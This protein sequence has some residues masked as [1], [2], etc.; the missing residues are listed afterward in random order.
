[1]KYKEKLKVYL[2]MSVLNF[3]FALDSPAEMGIT[4]KF[5]G[6][7]RK[8][9]FEAFIS[10]VVIREIYEAGEAKRGKLMKLV[11]KNR[12]SVIPLELKCEELADQYV[13]AGLVPLKYRD[14]ALHVAIA[15]FADIDIILSW[16]LTH[17][18]KVK[19]II[20]VNQV[21]EQLG[22]GRIDIRTPG[23]VIP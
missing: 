4:K 19:T 11:R 5:F 13:N 20:G 16:N 18:V 15:V 1:M 12:L 2:D 8:G 10:D 17:L 22:L 9:S 23:E 6:E 7:L 3:Y 14:D 21:N